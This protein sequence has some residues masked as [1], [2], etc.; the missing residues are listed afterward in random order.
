MLFAYLLLGFAAHS[1]E[2]PVL[3]NAKVQLV[4]PQLGEGGLVA[5]LGELG[6]RNL[7]GAVTYANRFAACHRFKASGE[8]LTQDL[9]YKT[10][11]RNWAAQYSLGAEYQCFFSSSA[12][13][14]LY[15]AGSY[16][17]AYTKGRGMNRL[18][19]SDG[20]QG[21]IGATINPWK[22]AYLSCEVD[23]DYIH[24]HSD[25]PSQKKTA[26]GFG[27]S[28]SLVQYLGREFSLRAD[29][30]FHQPYYLYE[31][32]F[33]WSRVYTN[34]KLNTG[35]YMNYTYGRGG[36]PNVLGGGISL[37]LSFGERN[38]KC[39]RVDSKWKE[40]CDSNWMC[41]LPS[42]ALESAARLPVVLALKDP[43]STC[44]IP[45]STTIPDQVFAGGPTYSFDTSPYFFSS[46]TLT[47]S[48]TGLPNLSTIN[49]ATGVISGPSQRIIDIPVTVTATSSCGSTSQSFLISFSG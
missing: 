8:F 37:S 14:N 30:E 7:R 20:G 12:F 49:P 43:I 19:G 6:A 34:F 28:T 3:P 13:R 9:R 31:G 21:R 2:N 39:C 10:G 36:L 16:I 11:N 27:G 42:W 45:T 41:D 26:S 5:F 24:Y 23:Y 18:A 4:T 1:I 17:H 33:E 29:A 15:A 22:C 38:E 44:S 48:A 46:S 40:K 35:L 32:A 25:L 47:Y